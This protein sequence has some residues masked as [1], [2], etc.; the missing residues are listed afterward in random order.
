MEDEEHPHTLDPIWTLCEGSIPVD[1]VWFCLKSQLVSAV[2]VLALTLDKVYQAW[3]YAL[4]VV[5]VEGS[6]LQ[7]LEGQVKWVAPPSLLNHLIQIQNIL[8]F[9][10]IMVMQFIN[11]ICQLI[12]SNNNI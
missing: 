2:A 5:E 9:Y 10:K 3:T 6:S 8:T 11:Q 4:E 12:Y 1:F 7:Q